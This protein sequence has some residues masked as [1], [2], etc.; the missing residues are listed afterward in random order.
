MLSRA[1]D[2][3]RQTSPSVAPSVACL[4]WNGVKEIYDL[5]FIITKY[6]EKCGLD[7]QLVI[8]HS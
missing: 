6:L 1:G 3:A 5:M 7:V 8:S 4:N 2:H